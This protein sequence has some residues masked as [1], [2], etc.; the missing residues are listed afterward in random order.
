MGTVLVHTVIRL[1]SF[2]KKGR[3][4]ICLLQIIQIKTFP[5]EV[6]VLRFLSEP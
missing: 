1:G 6:F 3:V 5:G 2:V 4:T